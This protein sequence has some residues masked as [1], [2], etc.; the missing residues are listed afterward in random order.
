MRSPPA[1]LSAGARGLSV[2]AL[3]TI[4]RQSE[5]S[6]IVANAHRI[7]RGEMPLFSRTAKD[8]FLFH[9]VEPEAVA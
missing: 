9:I 4:F 1:S 7:N 3:D 8:F 5:E 6:L 2:V